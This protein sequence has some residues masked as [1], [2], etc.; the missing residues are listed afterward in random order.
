MLSSSEVL[1]RLNLYKTKNLINMLLSDIDHNK[2]KTQLTFYVNPLRYYTLKCV[3]QNSLT[4]YFFSV[5][6]ITLT[7]LFAIKEYIIMATLINVVITYFYNMLVDC[8]FRC[9]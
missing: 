8:P 1:F 3:G 9:K 4:K 2:T 7:N 5:H 6:V